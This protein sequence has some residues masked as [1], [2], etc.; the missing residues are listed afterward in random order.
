MAVESLFPTD[1]SLGLTT[2]LYQ[3]TMAAGYFHGGLHERSACFEAFVRRLPENRNYLLLAGLEQI[4]HYL[5]R[6]RFTEEQTAWLASLPVF[7][8]VSSDF[9]DYLRDLRFTADAWAMPEGTVFYPNE[10]VLRI[11]GDLIQ[12]Q[13]VETYVLTCLNMQTLVASKAARVTRAAQGRPVADFGMRRAHGPMAGLLA[14]RGA[15]IGGCTGTSNVEAARRLGVRPVG[16]QA[17]S[18][19]MSFEQEEEAFRRYAEVFGPHTVCLVDTYDTLSGV[20]KALAVEDDLRA[21]RLD[22]GDLLTLSTRVREILDDAGRTDTKIL[23]SGDL[24]EYRIDELLRAG[25]PIDLFGVGTEMVTSL[26]APALS[27][28]YKLVASEDETGEIVPRIKRSSDKAT[29]GGAK[30][31]FRRYDDAGLMQGDL[32]TRADETAEGAPLLEP[33][34]QDGQPRRRLPDL[35]AIVQRARAQLDALPEDLRALRSSA[36][37]PV[38]VSAGLRGIQPR[39]EEE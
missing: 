32:L 19:V 21:V 18:W 24:N 37:Y 8:R 5:T 38:D 1:H 12:A 17:H 35:P 2:D 6:L 15:V 16:T 25:A 26:D 31:V 7:E 22:S 9:F 34:L 28:V 3:L 13:L 14:A 4:V 20:R 39:I 23:A 27:F 36:S 11:Q 29:L 33:I 30:Q 10:P